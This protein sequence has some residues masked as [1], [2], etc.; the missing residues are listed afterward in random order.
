VTGADALA[1]ER[2]QAQ[3]VLGWPGRMISASKSGYRRAHPDNAA[4]FNANVCLAAGKI[5]HGDLD[6]T[7]DEQ[8]L[9]DL[10]ARVGQT[11]YVLYEQDGRFENEC[12]PLLD[13]AVYRAFPD[14]QTCFDQRRFL[15]DEQR[16]LRHVPP[17][18][19]RSPYIVTPWDWDGSRRWRLWQFWRLQ[20]VRTSNPAP[21]RR[22]NRLLYLGPRGEGHRSPLLVLG[23]FRTL[24]PERATTVELTWYPSRRPHLSEARP[25][26][27]RRHRL[28]RIEL[29][30]YLQRWPG[31]VYEA[32][33]W[34]EQ[35]GRQ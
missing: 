18:A 1:R 26:L 4:I 7:L 33:L 2:D 32:R 22:I 12:E 31:F 11:T 16:A 19:R 24:R 25:K 34:V 35:A 28:G 13:Q 21:R 8:Q 17:P 5:W 9:L 20:L 3:V 14:G 10:A 6:L 30:V 27:L 29:G 15:R 23:L